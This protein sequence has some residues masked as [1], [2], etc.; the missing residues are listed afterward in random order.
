MGL[1][2]SFDRSV[3]RVPLI[4]GAGLLMR[5]ATSV[6]IGAAESAARVKIR[7]ALEGAEVLIDLGIPVSR[8]ADLEDQHYLLG[9]SRYIAGCA[10]AQQLVTGWDGVVDETGAAI[11]F[12]ASLI[13]KLLLEDTVLRAFEGAAYAV[14][15]AISI[16]GERSPP[17]PNG[18]SPA[19][20][21]TAGPAKPKTSPAAGAGQER[22]GGSAHSAADQ[23]ASKE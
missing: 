3:R 19:E 8:A 5:P 22:T 10:L 9:L 20:A 7:A 6:E 16:E 15:E 1:R 13:P 18:S 23:R 17:S 11:A 2:I 4:G 14:R 12:D 21:T